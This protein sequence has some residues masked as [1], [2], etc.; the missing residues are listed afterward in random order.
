M[1]PVWPYTGSLDAYVADSDVPVV[2]SLDY[3]YMAADHE[4]YGT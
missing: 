2:G 4:R 3:A 1:G